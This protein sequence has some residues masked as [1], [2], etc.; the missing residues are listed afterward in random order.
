MTDAE[1]E[2]GTRAQMQWARMLAGD[3]VLTYH[4]KPNSTLRVRRAPG[5][6]GGYLKV[7]VGT[8]AHMLVPAHG[9][10]EL[11]GDCIVSVEETPTEA[12]EGAE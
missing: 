2:R 1:D 10:I 4:M 7:D 6:E 8:V 9:G 5:R 11:D 3:C 12:A